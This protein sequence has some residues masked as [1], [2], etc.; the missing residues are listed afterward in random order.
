MTGKSSLK[1]DKPRIRV[2]F[3]EL[4]ENDLVLLSKTDTKENSAGELITLVEGAPVSIYEHN[5]YDDGLEEYLLADGIVEANKLFN[6]GEWS[7]VCKWN[8]RINSEGIIAV[9]NENK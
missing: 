1:I 3:N 2:D 5:L 7:S 6:S 9:T 8:C 4:V